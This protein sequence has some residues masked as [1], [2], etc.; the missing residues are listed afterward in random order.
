MMCM[1]VQPTASSL[2]AVVDPGA[3]IVF[4]GERTPTVAHALVL[5]GSV[6]PGFFILTPAQPICSQPSSG[7]P[8]SAVAF[9][10]SSYSA[11]TLDRVLHR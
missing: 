8:A 5:D 2:G 7:E 3:A 1:T 10:R 6:A 9:D 11:F 4:R